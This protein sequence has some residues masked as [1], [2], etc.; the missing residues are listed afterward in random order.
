MHESKCH[1]PN[2][3]DTFPKRVVSKGLAVQLVAARPGP[4]PRGWTEAAE[5]QPREIC[6]W[7]AGPGGGRGAALGDLSVTGWRALAAAEG[8]PGEICGSHFVTNISN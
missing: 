4:G 8:Q 1:A 7:L 6:G 2:V 3:P 5:R